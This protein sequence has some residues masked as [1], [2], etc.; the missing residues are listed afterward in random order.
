MVETRLDIKTDHGHFLTIGDVVDG[1]LTF[2]I[3]P[4]NKLSDK[5]SVRLNGDDLPEF[6]KALMDMLKRRKKRRERNGR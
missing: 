2:A 4:G 1:A 6:E 5:R 3:C